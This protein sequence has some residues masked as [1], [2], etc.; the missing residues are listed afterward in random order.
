MR[1]DQWL[2]VSL[3]VLMTAAFIWGRFHYDIVAVGALL[4]ALIAGL[5]TPKAAFSGFADGNCRS[6]G[7]LRGIRV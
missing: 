5:V 6:P 4:F 7:S 2:V 3:I 1:I